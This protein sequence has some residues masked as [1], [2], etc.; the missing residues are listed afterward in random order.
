VGFLA[1]P[2]LVWGMEG[3]KEELAAWVERVAGE[4]KA[5]GTHL[6]CAAYTTPAGDGAAV[7]LLKNQRPLIKQYWALPTQEISMFQN[8]D[9]VA[10]AASPY[11]TV[12]LKLAG[13]PVADTIPTEGATGWAEAEPSWRP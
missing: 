2:R 6:A 11:Q 9:V 8:G 1:E 4:G 13:A 7:K 12:Q 3:M 10:G 5:M